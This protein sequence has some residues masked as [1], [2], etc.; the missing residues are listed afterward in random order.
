[1]KYNI[2]ERKHCSIVQ[3][4]RYGTVQFKK[5]TFDRNECI[6][7]FIREKLSKNVK[8]DYIVRKYCKILQIKN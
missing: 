5:N 3:R 6:E 2:L 1:M 4:V 7:D 8:K